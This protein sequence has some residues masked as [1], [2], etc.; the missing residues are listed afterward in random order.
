MTNDPCMERCRPLIWMVLVCAGSLQFGCYTPPKPPPATTVPDQQAT[1]TSPVDLRPYLTAGRAGTWVYRRRDLREGSDRPEVQYVRRI[2][3]ERLIE[4][5]ATWQIYRTVESRLPTAGRDQIRQLVDP[6]GS[7]GSFVLRFALVE[8]MPLI[9]PDLELFEPSVGTTRLLYTDLK[10]QPQGHGMLSRTVTVE[11]FEDVE[12]PA[13]HFENCLRLRVELVL[14]VGWGLTINWTM[15]L[16]LSP[17]VGDVRRVQQL[18]GWLLIFPFGSSFEYEL[19]SYAPAPT[20]LPADPSMPLWRDGIIAFDR[21]VPHPSMGA[22]LVYFTEE[23]G[24]E[25]MVS[26]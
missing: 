19:A 7:R 24:V 22:L 16:W 25:T 14:E 12:C 15:Y 8:P 13:G 21:G 10:G 26:R 17:A 2:T 9:P 20:T 18:S 1:A 4:G 3:P 11:G 6:G 23:R 5:D